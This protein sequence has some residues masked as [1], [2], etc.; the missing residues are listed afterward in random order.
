[1][2]ASVPDIID[3]DRLGDG[4]KLDDID[5][6]YSNLQR[7]IAAARN[8]L[9]R[10]AA[11]GD[12]AQELEIEASLEPLFDRCQKIA[13]EVS[14]MPATSPSELLAKARIMLDRIDIDPHDVG[15]TLIVSLCRDLGLFLKGISPPQYRP[16]TEVA[17]INR[18]AS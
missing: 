11:A 16:T 14:E 2:C 1:M 12:T 7:T 13:W 17:P 9:A 5:A 10:S 3:R 15:C 18:S 4:P 6:E 8:A